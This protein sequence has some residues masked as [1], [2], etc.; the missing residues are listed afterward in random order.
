MNYHYK[1]ITL[2]NIDTNIIII[3]FV[4]NNNRII[5]KKIWQHLPMQMIQV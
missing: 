4:A 2:I 1:L 5:D 3:I